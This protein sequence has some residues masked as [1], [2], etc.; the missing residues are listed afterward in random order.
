MG[1]FERDNNWVVVF[2][3]I[4]EEECEVLFETFPEAI[5]FVVTMN[6]MMGSDF[7]C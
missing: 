7:I 3:V 4:D 5:D 6:E 1:V 2:K